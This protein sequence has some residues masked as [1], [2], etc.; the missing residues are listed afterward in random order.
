MTVPAYALGTDHRLEPSDVGR[1]EGNVSRRGVLLEANPPLRPRDGN[2]IGSSMEQPGKRQLRRGDAFLRR[3]VAEARGD[4]HVDD[5]YLITDDLLE[6]VAEI[7]GFY[8]NYHSLRWVGDRLVIRLQA[9]PTDSEVAVLCEEF[10][11]VCLG[12]GIEVLP[13]PLP[14]EVREGD[15]L[16]L[17]RISLRFDRLSHSHLRRLIRRSQ[18][19]A[20]RSPA[21]GRPSRP[22]QSA[23]MAMTRPCG[24]RSRAAVYP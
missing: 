15:H 20:K 4:R 3:D 9:R 17:A 10:A 5:L 11:G 7:L 14:T 13:G 12:G 2:D 6:A 22:A 16:E 1:L 18:F 19:T 21:A 24:D 23:G 8:R